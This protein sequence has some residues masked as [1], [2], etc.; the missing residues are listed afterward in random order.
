MNDN[1]GLN[2]T[3]PTLAFL[4]SAIVL[5][6]VVGIFATGFSQEFFQLAP[7]IVAVAEQL[8][9]QPAHAFGLRLNLGLDNLF[10]VVYCAI[11]VLLAVRLRGLLSPVTI[12]VALAALLLTGLL[13]ALENQ[14][15]LAVLHALQHGAPLS[16]DE[17]KF[18]MVESNLKFH[19]SYIGSFLFAFGFF[20]LGGLGRVI[21]W[22]L[23]LGY[24][25][26][27]MI[28]FAVPAETTVPFA[29]ARTAFFELAFALAGVHFLRNQQASFPAATWHNEENIGAARA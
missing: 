24:V 4:A 14:H 23:W 22:L 6:M 3:L 28:T 25:P 16:S 27:G 1:M 26:L 20:R 8:S 17:L 7:S 12:G 10:I 13:D 18:E 9:D 21:A 29:L 11:F 2:R 5:C 15:I 19:A